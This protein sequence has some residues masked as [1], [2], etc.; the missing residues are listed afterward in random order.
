VDSGSS[1]RPLPLTDEETAPFLIHAGPTHGVVVRRLQLDEARL[2]DHCD[3]THTIASLKHEAS[4]HGRSPQETLTLL[5]RLIEEGVIVELQ[6]S[7]DTA[8]N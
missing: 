5:H 4:F 3:G 1:L 6:R 8:P 2:L 7:L